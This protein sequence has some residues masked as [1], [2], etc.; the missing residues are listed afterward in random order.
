VHGEK[1]GVI[2]GTYL[3]LLSRDPVPAEQ[4][5]AEAYWATPG[6]SPADAANDLAWALINSTEFQYRH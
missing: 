6:L 3:V 2:R 5:A 1:A 4:A